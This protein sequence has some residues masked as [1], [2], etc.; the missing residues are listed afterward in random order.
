MYMYISMERKG[1]CIESTLL[2]N[3]VF[4]CLH[5]VILLYILMSCS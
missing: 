4:S 2:V 1:L 3:C 5:V